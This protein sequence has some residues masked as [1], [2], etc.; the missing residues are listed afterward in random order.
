MHRQ[1][2]SAIFALNPVHKAQKPHRKSRAQ[3]KA[4]G[5]RRAM[6]WQNLIGTNGI[7]SKADL[8]KYLGVSR[9]RVTHV[10][11]RLINH[12]HCTIKTAS[13]TSN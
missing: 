6:D 8:A 2:Q 7:K 10:F 12:Q 4:E 13:L 3:I 11:K 9:A 1:R 5:I